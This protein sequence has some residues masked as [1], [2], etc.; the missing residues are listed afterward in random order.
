[1]LPAMTLVSQWRQLEAG[2]PADWKQARLSLAV[3]DITEVDRAAALLGPLA[4]GRSRAQLNFAVTRGSWP[5]PDAVRRLLG[6]LDEERIGGRL[7]L[8]EAVAESR[9]E[10]A[11]PP[12]GLAGSWDE[13]VSTFPEDWSDLL[14][15]LDLTSSDDLP[16]AALLTAPLNPTREHGDPP[17]FRFRVARRFGYGT[18]PEMTRRCL[19]RLDEEA[20]PGRLRVLRVLS[21][22]KPVATQGPVWY[23]GGK[24]V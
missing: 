22:T 15:H 20:I 7:V 18:S 3:A 4:P 23:I 1:M 16:R 8:L 17:G 13:L 2:L 12:A 5:G 24:A 14:C 21:D 11:R 10:E 6:R 19:A 9:A